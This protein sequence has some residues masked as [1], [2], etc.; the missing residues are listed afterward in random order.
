M[1]LGLYAPLGGDAVC[2]VRGGNGTNENAGNPMGGAL[3]ATATPG[4]HHCAV[5]GAEADTVMR[6]T[7]QCC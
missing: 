6:D 4:G 2:A 5:L 1:V 3:G 7:R